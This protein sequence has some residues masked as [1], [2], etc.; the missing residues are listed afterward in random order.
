M[1]WLRSF[2]QYFSDIFPGFCF[3]FGSSERLRPQTRGRYWDATTLV[4]FI[5]FP[6]IEERKLEGFRNEV[7]A[8][9]VALTLGYLKNELEF[10]TCIFTQVK[11]LRNGEVTAL[12]KTNWFITRERK[13]KRGAGESR[14]RGRERSFEVVIISLFSSFLFIIKKFKLVF[15]QFSHIHF[16]KYF[17]LFLNWFLI[18]WN[19]FSDNIQI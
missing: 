8:K 3:H 16:L 6:Y 1:C 9:S 14:G 12:Q 7:M 13:S 2:G 18:I 10:Y 4:V 19:A 15:K 5:S 17:F 11:T